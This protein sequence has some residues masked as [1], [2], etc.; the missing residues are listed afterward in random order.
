MRFSELKRSMKITPKVLSGRL[1]EL[2]D[3]EL[4]ENRIDS[5]CTPIK[6]EYK[7]TDKGVDLIDVAKSVKR[8]GLK[9]KVNNPVC[10]SQDCID[11]VL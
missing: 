6:S 5:S 7:L 11:C 2:V 1:K 4:I 9:W 10:E 8:W 3:E